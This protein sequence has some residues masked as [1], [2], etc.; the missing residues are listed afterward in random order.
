MFRP[1]LRCVCVCWCTAGDY[2][3]QSAFY[4]ALSWSYWMQT[5]FCCICCYSCRAANLRE[6]LCLF[7]VVW[8][9]KGCLAAART[10]VSN[11]ETPAFLSTGSTHSTAP[12]IITENTHKHTHANILCGLFHLGVVVDRDQR[13]STLDNESGWWKVASD[14]GPCWAQGPGQILL[15][16][17]SRTYRGKTEDVCVQ[18]GWINSKKKCLYL[19]KRA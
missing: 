3:L 4:I 16:G 6:C 14:G 17:T 9:G 19:G 13:G 2:S 18:A 11:C 15:L 12:P 10:S 7:W 8:E 1:F 5:V